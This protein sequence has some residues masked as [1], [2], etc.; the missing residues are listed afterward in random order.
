MSGVCQIAITLLLEIY[1][2]EY[3]IMSIQISVRYT[4]M[5]MTS[6]NSAAAHLENYTY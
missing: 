5:A 2:A 1:S 3:L 6:E 4:A